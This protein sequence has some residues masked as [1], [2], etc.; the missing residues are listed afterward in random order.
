MTKTWNLT[1]TPQNGP[2]T[3]YEHVP[4][5]AASIALFELLYGSG[6]FDL[7]RHGEGG[8]KGLALAA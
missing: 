5:D 1:L 4:A 3:K 7:P 8:G 6:S 2:A